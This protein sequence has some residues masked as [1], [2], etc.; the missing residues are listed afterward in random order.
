MTCDPP[1]SRSRRTTASQASYE[2]G[3]G[4]VGAERADWTSRSLFEA[5]YAENRGLEGR[6]GAV[7]W[8]TGALD[9]SKHTAGNCDPAVTGPHHTANTPGRAAGTPDRTSS[10]CTR[11]LDRSHHSVD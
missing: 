10:I 7:G 11:A 9:R 1:S 4:A 8:I 6:A 3:T 5:V 2:I